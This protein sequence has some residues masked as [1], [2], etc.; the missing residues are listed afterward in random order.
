MGN[1]RGGWPATTVAILLATTGC[2]AQ[3]GPA[4]PSQPSPSVT[5]TADARKSALAEAAKSLPALLSAPGPVACSRQDGQW[6][7]T[8]YDDAFRTRTA[9][10]SS[11]TLAPLLTE[12]ATKAGGQEA[13]VRSLCG[14]KGDPGISPVSPDGRR[15]AVQVDFPASGDPTHVGW[16]DLGTGTFTDLTDKSNKKGYVKETFSDKYPGF[17][18]DGSFWFLRDSQQFFSADPNGRLTPRRLSLACFSNRNEDTFYQVVRSVAVMCEGTVHPSG[19]FAA[20]PSG[21]AKGM[22]LVQGAELDILA[23]TVDRYENAPLQLPFGMKVAVRDHGR[24]QDCSP[25]AWVNATDLLCAGAGNNFYTV[26]IDPKTARNDI[27]YVQSTEVKVK[28][29]IAPVTETMISSVALSRDRRSLIIV[30]DQENTDTDQLYR[31][32]LVS[33][34]DP[35]EIG[36]VPAESKEHFTLL[37][38]YQQPVR[39]AGTSR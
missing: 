39:A 2:A 38:N 24:L 17:A 12:I 5:V 1:R 19:R 20:D 8:A 25:V 23:N 16:L 18:P 28:A 31:A 27:E 35:V 37:G 34:S 36:P 9:T 33:P 30:A 7:A 11:T 15:V 10:F 22:T 13:F 21:V 26:Q 4:A 32:S 14:E 29:E 3:A 6:Q